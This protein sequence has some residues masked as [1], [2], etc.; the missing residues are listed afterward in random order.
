MDEICPQP[1]D[2]AKLK[3]Y[4]L[5]E[6]KSLTNIQDILL[7]PGDEPLADKSACPRN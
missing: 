4:P 3:V 6:R 2:L 1:L 5:A 7:E